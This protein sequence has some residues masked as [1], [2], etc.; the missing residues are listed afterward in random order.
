MITEA[1]AASPR[2]DTREPAL[3]ARAQQG[4]PDAFAELYRRHHAKVFGFVYKRVG[5]DRTLSEDLTSDVFV[6]VLSKLSTFT[7]TGTSIEAWLCTIARNR[8]IDH[9]KVGA[10]Q[11][12]TYCAEIYDIAD[13]WAAAEVATEDVVLTGIAH[14][15]LHDALQGLRPS[16]K[17][18]LYLRFFRGY[19]VDETATTMRMSI[20]AVKTMQYRATRALTRAMAEVA[21]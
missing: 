20:G 14:T 6:R 1:N 7:W 4:D 16:Q 9:Y 21:A 12:V 13:R 5:Y 2:S 15:E 19:S 11:Q 18:V 10:K 17:A 3:V 8:V